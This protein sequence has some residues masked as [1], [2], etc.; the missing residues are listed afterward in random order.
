MNKFIKYFLK[1]IKIK[2]SV[3]FLK[4]KNNIVFIN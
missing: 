3:N 4:I 1:M 2:K